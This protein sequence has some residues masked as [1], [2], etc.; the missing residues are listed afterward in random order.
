MAIATRA[1]KW[2]LMHC[3]W[4]NSFRSACHLQGECSALRTF[5]ETYMCWADLQ[6]FQMMFHTDRVD[7]SEQEKRFPGNRLI[8][9]FGMFLQ[10]GLGNL[11]IVRSVVYILYAHQERNSIFIFMSAIQVF[12][13]FLKSL[14]TLLISTETCLCS[15][16]VFNIYAEYCVG[17]NSYDLDQ[18]DIFFFSTCMLLI[19]N[20]LCLILT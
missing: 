2:R 20:V 17:F 5:A 9:S 3:L 14:L 12:F 11:E 7:L 13:R 19:I 8:D 18:S 15:F 1:Q 6:C 10:N 16:G 4:V